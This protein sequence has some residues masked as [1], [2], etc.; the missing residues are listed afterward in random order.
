MRLGYATIGFVASAI[1]VSNLAGQQVG[2]FPRIVTRGD[3]TTLSFQEDAQ[4][5]QAVSQCRISV[6]GGRLLVESTGEDPYI[7]RPLSLPGAEYEVAVRLRTTV[8]GSGAIYWITAKSPNWA[9][10]K[11]RHFS[12][13][14]DGQWHTYVYR[15]KT[16]GGL[17][18]L[19]IDPGTAPGIYEIES[20]SLTELKVCA[21]TV[22]SV[23]T[24]NEGV[25][26]SLRNE[27]DNAVEIQVGQESILVPAGGTTEV[28]RR[29]EKNRLLQLV[30]VDFRE[31]ESD[32]AIRHSVA[33]YHHGAPAE[34]ITIS[35][36]DNQSVVIELAAKE[37]VLRIC[38]GNTTVLV[39]APIVGLAD[40]NTPG[41]IS[42]IPDLQAISIPGG[43]RIK[44]EGVQGELV[45]DNGELLVTLEATAAAAEI[46][47]PVVRV[48]GS[49][50]QGVFAG[51]EYLGK[52][53]KSSSTLDIETEEHI[54]F[55]PHRLQVTMPLMAF[56]TDRV[57]VGLT[58]N[59][60]ELQPVY[61]TPNVF[62]GRDEHRMSLRGRK[63]EA[64]LRVAEGTVEDTILWATKRFGLPPLPKPPR[65]ESE[66]FA[67]CLWALTDGPIRNDQGWGHCVEP[68]WARR[69]H[70]DMVSTI[71]RLSGKLV[72]TPTL[73]P[74]GGHLSDDSAWF[75]TGRAASWLEHLR[76]QV[77]GLMAQQQPDGSFRYRGKYQKGH[78]EDTAS[79]YCARP[80]AVLLEYAKLTGD[81]QA[82]SAGLKTLDYMKRFRVPR[83]AQTWELSLH[84]PD[85]LASAHLVSAYVRGYELTGRQDY[86]AEARRWALSGVPFVY[87]WA[88]QPV[89]LYATIPVYGATNWRAPNWIGLPVQWCGLVYAYSLTELA[90]Y[91]TTLDWR[92]LAEGILIAGEQMQVPREEGDY[93]GLLPDSFH[94]AYQ[95]RQGP[96]INP[97]ALALLRLAV[98]GQPHRLSVA[99]GD[100]HRVVAPFPVRI[101]G[102]QVVIQGRVGLAYQVLVDGDRIVKID[103]QGEDRISLE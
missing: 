50:E 49:L 55:A 98:N 34:W 77:N 40:P 23:E 28:F 94:L 22:T 80:A 39:L 82:L 53:E 29:L 64:R 100:R 27:R 43:V 72:E 18:G 102:N 65:S 95:R 37:N 25:R 69:F 13:N 62:D 86:L 63:I 48:F 52:G 17:R 8:A 46:E 36:P 1:W 84:T 10:D 16:P 24:T 74:G 90:R 58:W 60:M 51:L 32:V 26:F 85:I 41:M 68:N 89:M 71:W 97:C 70:A 75:L 2:P 38:R 31:D 73:V 67:L 47:G 93:A 79:G 81:E 12:L 59:D 15:I 35:P 30:S 87:L 61:A 66:Q 45:W 19:R 91:D 21:V 92:H 7:V 101:E 56:V 83:G 4:G 42:K 76:N 9:E 54:R 57:S 44:G 14:S 96:F 20:V 5:F 88:E 33:V 103:S 6:H 3:T 11:S 78:Y 99:I